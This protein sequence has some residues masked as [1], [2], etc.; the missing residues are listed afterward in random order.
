MDTSYL[1]VV[2][3][4]SFVNHQPMPGIIGAK[5]AVNRTVRFASCGKGF[6]GSK[7]RG[8]T[9]TSPSVTGPLK[10]VTFKNCCRFFCDNVAIFFVGLSPFFCWIEIRNLLQFS[11]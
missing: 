7:N 3:R 10:D 4:G 6:V 1:N 5:K 11:M 8:V 2:F 9:H